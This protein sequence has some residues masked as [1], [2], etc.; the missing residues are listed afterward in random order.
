MNSSNRFHPFTLTFHREALEQA[1]LDASLAPTLYQGRF[2]IVVGSLV[3]VLTAV[4]DR[5]F[6]PPEYVGQ[7]WTTRL[8]A[9]CMPTLVFA[10]SYTRWFRGLRHLLLAAVGMAAGVGV[11]GMQ[12]FLPVEDA[13]P[14]YP[15]MAL[16]TFFT[17]NFVGT[18]FVY[19]LCVDLLLVFSYNFVFGFLI[20]YP[21]HILV[22]HDFLIVSANLVG[23][24]AGYLAERQRRILFLRERELEEANL[25]KSR[26][27]AAA[28]HDLRQPLHA[29]NLLIELLRHEGNPA[30]ATAVLDHLGTAAESLEEL[31]NE[32]LDISKLEAGMFHPQIGVLELQDVFSSLERELR[33]V[34]DEKGIELGFVPTRVR[35]RSDAQMLGRILRNI[36]TN[37]IRH[38]KQG[39]VLVG[40]RRKADGVAIAIYDTGPGIAPEHHDAIFR[41]FYQLDNPE[42]D[43]RKGLGLGLAIV[44]GLCRLLEH[45]LTLRSLVGRGSA[46]FVELPVVS[47]DEAALTSV[48]VASPCDLT[49]ST[50]LVIDDEPAI[51]QA[52]TDVLSH[53]GCRAITAES[54]EEA[55]A[56]L[57]T[58]Q[59]DPDAIVVDYRLRKGRTGAEAIDEIRQAVGRHVPALIVTGDTA[60]ERLREAS[61][62][63]S[64]LLQKPVKPAQLRTALISLRSQV[65]QKDYAD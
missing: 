32:L 65:I 47:G 62:S 11:I 40:C 59:I 25:A 56:R 6:V 57:A 39:A 13:A 43:R 18:S 60:P 63:G 24:S 31:L 42:R 34:A 48:Q 14:F 23:G 3:F 22:S 17:Y 46:F 19:A 54:A 12:A 37:A 1:F 26:F 64:L 55:L 2:A 10:V 50:V 16:A 4:L 15:A 45:R 35:V 7:I 49:G 52:M 58:E 51:C 36:I 8:T 28:S 27:L 38:T 21:L 29:V 53:W 30:K 41:E 20:G 33:P 5:W 9:L 44:D 61:A